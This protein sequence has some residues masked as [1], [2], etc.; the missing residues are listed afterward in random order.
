MTI[1][2]LLERLAAISESM[3]YDMKEPLN[4]EVK[5]NETSSNN[6]SPGK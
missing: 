2:D 3:G 4:I 1:S 6:H 5:K